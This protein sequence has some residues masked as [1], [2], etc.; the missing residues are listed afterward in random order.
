[1]GRKEKA[2]GGNGV[3]IMRNEMRREDKESSSEAN[4]PCLSQLL[5]LSSNSFI[6]CGYLYTFLLGRL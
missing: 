5:P 2:V 3:T 4:H 6:Y 1:M